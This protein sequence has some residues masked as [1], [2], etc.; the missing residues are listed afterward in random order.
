MMRRAIVN[1][2]E[3]PLEPC[4]AATAI[5]HAAT[6]AIIAYA[7]YGIEMKE[8]RLHTA[9]ANPIIIPLREGTRR[10]S[11]ALPQLPSR[12][13]PQQRSSRMQCMASR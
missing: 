10:W 11:P 5:T 3:P 9:C 8:Q 6:A 1:M 13:P 7:V 4:T 12:T 2:S